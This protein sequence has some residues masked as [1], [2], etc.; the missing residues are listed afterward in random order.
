MHLRAKQNQPQLYYRTKLLIIPK[1]QKQEEIPQKR[2]S[3]YIYNINKKL[4]SKAK[5]AKVNTDT[6]CNGHPTRQTRALLYE[7]Q[8]PSHETNTCVTLRDATA[9]FTRQTRALLHEMQRPSH[10]TNTCVTPRDRHEL[11]KRQTRV[12]QER[13]IR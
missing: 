7:M 5:L 4:Q 2:N 10:E 9:I 8:R 1:K 3:K 6:R 13:H 12:T 11:L